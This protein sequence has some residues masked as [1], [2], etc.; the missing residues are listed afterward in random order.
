MNLSIILFLLYGIALIFIIRFIMAKNTP[1]IIQ[2]ESPAVVYSDASWWAWSTGTYNYWPYWAGWWSGGDDGGY[3]YSHRR[4]PHP[5]PRFGGGP[6]GQLGGRYGPIGI[7]ASRPGGGG[8][9]GHMGGGRGG[10][11]HGGGRR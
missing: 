1:I 4:Y 8:M 5:R 6:R 2:Q 9:G 10:G 11:G 7:P 3:G